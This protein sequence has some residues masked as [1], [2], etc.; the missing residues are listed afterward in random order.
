[1]KGIPM[2]A[3]VTTLTINPNIVHLVVMLVVPIA[4][5]ILSHIT[6]SVR[7][8]A[9]VALVLS[10]VGTLVANATAVDGSAVLSVQMLADWAMVLVGSI[11]AYLGVLNPIVGNGALNEKLA[12]NFGIGKAA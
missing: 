10:G 9:I 7:V 2:L 8:K 6:A 4:T 3:T 5:G 12:P 1:M 11:A